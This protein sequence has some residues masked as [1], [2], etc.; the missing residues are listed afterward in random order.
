MRHL[1]L[2]GA[3]GMAE[4]LLDALAQSLPAPLEQLSLLSTGS[5]R[6]AE[7]VA[8]FGKGIA[9]RTAVHQSLEAMLADGA[10]VV[11][12]CAGH[13][14]VRQHG[15]AVLAAGR[16][17]VVISSGALADDALRASLEDAMR[18]GGGRLSLPAGAVGGIDVLAAARLSGLESVTYTG[19]KPPR[20]WKGTQ[21]ERAIDLESLSEPSVFF[22][23]SAREAATLYP[24]NA[25]VAAT[26][27]MARKMPTRRPC[28]R[29]MMGRKPL[30]MC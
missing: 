14:A 15:A 18:R 23:G 20:A 30:R 27:A 6:A 9:H 22:E 1:G 4:T 2:I 29:K 10:E 3:G 7:L 28:A 26:I 5:P 25:N 11:A 12:E 19:R 21:A 8:R 13:G 16:E 17:L 24:Q